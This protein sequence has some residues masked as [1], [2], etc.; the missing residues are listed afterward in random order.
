MP[1]IFEPLAQKASAC[2]RLINSKLAI[3]IRAT[4]Q[5]KLNTNEFLACRNLR[6]Q[7]NILILGEA[8]LYVGNKFL[9]KQRLLVGGDHYKQLWW[10]PVWKSQPI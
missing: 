10:L 7:L 6:T 1:F 4:E 9:H 8:Q 3:G 2:H 5:L